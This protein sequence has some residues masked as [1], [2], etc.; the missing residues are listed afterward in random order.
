MQ[1]NEEWKKVYG[2]EDTYLISKEGKVLAVDKIVNAAYG[3]KQL[4]K[5]HFMKIRT[6]NKGYFYFT[7]YKKRKYFIHKCIY[8]AFVKPIPDGYDLHHINH[9]H[10]DN[11]LENLCLIESSKHRS[12]HMKERLKDKG[13]A[14]KTVLQYTLDGKLV[15]E[16]PSAREAEKYVGF[17]IHLENKSSGGYLWCYKGEEN[18][19]T[20][21][22]KEYKEKGVE[23][24]V[25]QYTKSME[26]VAEYKSLTEAQEKTNNDARNICATCAGKRKSCGGYIWKYK[27]VA[28][29]LAA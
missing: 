29:G 21:K 15:A 13:I 25:V 4:R 11:R 6:N 3:S 19:I 1:P 23:R 14:S 7:T 27:N 17:R 16:Y 22:V 10:Q 9:N 26:F 24:A 28:E 12:M 8:E 20:E 5:Q 2:F 18:L